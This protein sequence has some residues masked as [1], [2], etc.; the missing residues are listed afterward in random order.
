MKDDMSPE[1][2]RVVKDNREKNKKVQDQKRTQE[3]NQ[4]EKNRG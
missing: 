2:R 3:R 1:D 4:R